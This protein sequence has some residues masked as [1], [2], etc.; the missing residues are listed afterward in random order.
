[1]NRCLTGYDLA[2]VYDAQGRFNLNAILCGA[3]GTLAFVAEAK[4]N[5]M[6]LPKHLALVNVKYESFEDT[7]RDTRE[8]M[9][10]DPAA[11]ESIDSIVLN[12]AMNDIV[13]DSVS[14]LFPVQEGKNIAGINLVEF[15]AEDDEELRRTVKALTGRLDAVSGQP[16]KCFGYTV[17]F[18]DAQLKRVWGM[19]KKA[20]GL[21]GNVA[22]EK[23]PIPFVEDTAVPPENLADYIMEFRA[24][25]ERENLAYGM[26]GHVDAGV[27]HVRP[28]IDMKDPK[29]EKLIRKLSDEVEALTRKYKGLL[30]GEHGKGV[31]SEY[32]PEFFGPLYPCL[33]SIKSACDPRNQLNPGKICTPA[34][35]TASLLKI[36]AVPARGQQDRNVPVAL[37]HEYAAAMNC[38]GNGA[39]YNFDP[40]DAM[41][42]SWKGTRERIHSPK[43]RASLTRE[44]LGPLGGG[45]IQPLAPGG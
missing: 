25:L 8:L 31:R 17:A 39:C 11:I 36:D 19:R 22:G 26:F 24:I 44:G 16:G 7:L 21:L 18:G 9:K 15:I 32:A 12:L 27:L 43:G 3:E 29:Q 30:W 34:A 2:H 41:C 23:R 37:R 35:S 42:P 6:P 13:W 33:Q 10:S 40:D 45:G 14:D 4:L 38:N 28:A 20:V 5:L 1:L